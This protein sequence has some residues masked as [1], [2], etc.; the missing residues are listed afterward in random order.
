MA[1]AQV[2]KPRICWGVKRG[3][4]FVCG[5]LVTDEAIIKEVKGLINGLKERIERHRDKLGTAAFIDELIN[6]FEQWLEEHKN[7]RGRRVRE[8]RKIAREMIKLLRMLRRRWVETYWR[9]LLELMDLLEKNAIDIV[10]TGK[11]TARSHS[12][13]TYTTGTWLLR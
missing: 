13:Y 5:E 1:M 11:I 12:W 9:Q 10:V 7:D 4:R 8:A 3:R 6:L 2:G